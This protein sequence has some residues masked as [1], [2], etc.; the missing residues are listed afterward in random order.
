MAELRET[1]WDSFTRV[2]AGQRFR[3]ASAAMG[4]ALTETIVRE[5]QIEPNLS[6]LDVAS[7]SGEPAISVAA[8]LNGTGHVVATDISPTPLKVAEQRARERGLTNIEFLPA[9]VHRLPLPDAAFD[10]I[11]CRLGVMF[12]ADLP[13]A[14]GELHR[15][16]RPSGRITLLAWGPM[17]QPYFETTIGTALNV[18]PQLKPLVSTVGMFKFGELGRL[19]SELRSAGFHSVSEEHRQLPW[20]WPGTPE[21]LWE[22]FQEVTIPFKP[23]LQAIPEER[24]EQV[25][26]KVLNALRANYRDGEV[27]FDATV[28][29]ASARR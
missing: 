17:Q 26:T 21:E 16:L 12:F 24:R 8:L 19:S 23:L 13:C 9:D 4:R 25:H 29:L 28:V 15:V 22:Y 20:N 6:V 7:G 27:K 1:A 11:L 2:N 3:K 10:R 14:F 18:L 5:A